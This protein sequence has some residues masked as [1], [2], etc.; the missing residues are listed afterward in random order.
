MRGQ[1]AETGP[2]PAR[3]FG[4][5]LLWGLA[6]I[7]G[8]LLLLALTVLTLAATRG[9]ADPNQF[10][11][12]QHALAMAAHVGLGA[13][14]AWYVA[15]SAWLLVAA[16]RWARGRQGSRAAGALLGLALAALLLA[17]PAALAVGLPQHPAFSL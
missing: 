1:S 9:A 16:G 3:G 10:F 12:E 2:G 11:A 13:V 8:A 4:S 17:L 15:S 6:P 5:G 7:M 14:A